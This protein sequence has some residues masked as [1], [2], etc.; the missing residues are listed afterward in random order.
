M[1]SSFSFMHY[2]LCV[3]PENYKLPSS[4]GGVVSF[5]FYIGAFLQERYSRK[6]AVQSN[7]EE[8]ALSSR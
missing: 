4:S 8:V 7:S 6:R 2:R 3:G 1:M 5:M